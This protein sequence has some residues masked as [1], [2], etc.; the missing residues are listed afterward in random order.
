MNLFP[1]FYRRGSEMDNIAWISYSI[2][3]KLFRTPAPSHSIPILFLSYMSVMFH[4]KDRE[5]TRAAEPRLSC[6]PCHLHQ[7][8]SENRL[9]LCSG[10]LHRIYHCR[11]FW[12]WT[13]VPPRLC[14]SRPKNKRLWTWGYFRIS[15]TD[16]AIWSST[17][18][19]LCLTRRLENG[20]LVLFPIK[21]R[22]CNRSKIMLLSMGFR[23]QDTF[24]TSESWCFINIHNAKFLKTAN[25][26]SK[27]TLT[28]VFAAVFCL[29][30]CV[31]LWWCLL[32]DRARNGT[33]AWSLLFTAAEEQNSE[34]FCPSSNQQKSPWNLAEQAVSYCWACLN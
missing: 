16:I 8:N 14:Q 29:S 25:W 17:L 4:E 28:H 30:I 13:T 31:T 24:S 5:P 2:D 22:H 15:R 21:Q 1:C 34:T 19:K 18:T 7:R 27:K 20:K 33:L 23:L 11:L 32:P 6:I 10:C 9:K 26:V 12:L 3:L